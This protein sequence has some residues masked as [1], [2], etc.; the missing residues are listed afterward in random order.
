MRRAHPRRDGPITPVTARRSYARARAFAGFVSLLVTACASG[1]GPPAAPAPASGGPSSS[2]TPIAKSNDSTTSLVG[3]A[4]GPAATAPAKERSPAPDTK[5]SAAQSSA[6]GE[7]RAPANDECGVERELELAYDR[8]GEDAPRNEWLENARAKILSPD[9]A[10][11]AFTGISQEILSALAHRRYEKLAA[12][13]AKDGICMRATTKAPCQMLSPRA[14]SGCAA[15]RV[16]ITWPV[17]PGDEEMPQYDCGDAFRHVFYSR[18]YLHVGA[19]RFNCFSPRSGGSIEAAVIG[20]GP[21]LGYVELSGEGAGRAQ[22]LWLVF[23]GDPRNPELVE[24]ISD[25]LR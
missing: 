16:H 7:S 1:T 2:N 19:P 18:D 13:A 4:S 5:A 20:S 22:T 8:I 21:H 10:E 11:R 6:S 17:G 12:F 9:V 14:L 15:S 24:M 3:T 25:S 23:D